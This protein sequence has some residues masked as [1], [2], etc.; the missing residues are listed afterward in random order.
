MRIA[1][2]TAA[3]SSLRRQR[4]RLG[5]LE[6]YAAPRKTDRAQWEE[7]TTNALL[8]TE[9]LIDALGE[10]N[11]ILRDMLATA[12]QEIYTAGTDNAAVD[13]EAAAAYAAA[14][15]GAEFAPVGGTDGT[16]G[17]TTTTTGSSGYGRRL[18]QRREYN[19][20][21]TDELITAEIME[22]YGSG[23]IPGVTQ[24]SCEVQFATKPRQMHTLPHV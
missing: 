3:A 1:H 11:P 23:G 5:D 12:K 17:T 13:E 14:T 2:D 18:L 20:R 21:M 10:N 7:D 16:D 9:A 24:A 4:E 15:S 19:V 8:G 22:F 6:A